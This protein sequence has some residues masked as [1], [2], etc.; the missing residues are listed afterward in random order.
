MCV[1]RG[2]HA[3]TVELLDF[4]VIDTDAQSYIICQ[5]SAILFTAE[6]ERREN[7]LQL[8]SQDTPHSYPVV[9]TVDGVF[10]RKAF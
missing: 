3:Q 6:R 8:L 5:V 2:S 9:V 10:G 1:V 7:T 4:C